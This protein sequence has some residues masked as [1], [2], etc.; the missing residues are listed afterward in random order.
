MIID[1]F[2]DKIFLLNNPNDFPHYISE[3]YISPR[4][5]S[6]S[7]SEDVSLRS[8]SPSHSV[9]I[10]PRSENPSHRKDELNEIIIKNNKTI[11]KELFRKIFPISRY[12]S[13]II[14][15]KVCLKRRIHKKIKN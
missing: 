6:T 3:E 5:E 13:Y 15:K 1:T 7:H 12:I 10:S 9:D 2:R 11:S 4:S 8:E 14:C